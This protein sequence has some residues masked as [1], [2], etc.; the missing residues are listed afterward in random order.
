M[1]LSPHA[2]RKK[3]N[4]KEDIEKGIK[5][6]AEASEIEILLSFLFIIQSSSLQINPA[7]ISKGF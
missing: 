4:L 5:D 7:I 6:E 2:K 3:K 1:H